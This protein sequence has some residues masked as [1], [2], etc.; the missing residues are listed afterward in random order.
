MTRLALLIIAVSGA[1]VDDITE[2][3][4]VRFVMKGGKVIR[5][6]VR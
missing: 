5:N 3:E 4:A 2:L 1:P 6:D